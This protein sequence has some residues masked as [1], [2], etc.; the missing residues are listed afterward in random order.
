MNQPYGKQEVI[1]TKG[2]GWTDL[3]N[4]TGQGYSNV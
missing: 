3:N 4:P 1:I 2:G